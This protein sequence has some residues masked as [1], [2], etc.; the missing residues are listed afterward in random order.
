M[1]GVAC[2]VGT[3]VGNMLVPVMCGTV[4][5]RCGTVYGVVTFAT[6]RYGTVRVIANRYMLL[7][8]VSGGSAR[9]ARNG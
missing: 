6:E 8:A 1:M 4:R 3:G 2:V 5:V 9:V 7:R